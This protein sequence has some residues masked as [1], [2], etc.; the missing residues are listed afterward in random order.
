MSQ[1]KLHSF[2]E[3]DETKKLEEH[4]TKDELKQHYKLAQHFQI[5]KA[6]ENAERKLWAWEVKTRF[7]AKLEAYKE[8]IARI[9]KMNPVNVWTS[10]AQDLWTQST[11]FNKKVHTTAKAKMKELENNSTLVWLGIALWWSFAG[12]MKYASGEKTMWWMVAD[13]FLKWNFSSAVDYFISKQI[14]KTDI[15][16]F[17]DY[18]K[19]L[20]VKAPELPKI[21]SAPKWDEDK[22]WEDSKWEDSKAQDTDNKKNE[23]WDK[24]EKKA[25]KEKKLDAEEKARKLAE[26]KRLAESKEKNRISTRAKLYSVWIGIIKQASLVTFM[27]EKEMFDTNFVFDSM[28]GLSLSSLSKFYWEYSPKWSNSLT[29]EENEKKLSTDLVWLKVKLW[30]KEN[31]VTYKAILLMLKSVVNQNHS[32]IIIKYKLGKKRLEHFF[33]NESDEIRGNFMKEW[34]FTKKEILAIRKN[35]FDYTYLTLEQVSII[36]SLSYPS[37][38][39]ANELA[40]W[41]MAWLFSWVKLEGIEDEIKA[42]RDDLLSPKIVSELMKGWA[43]SW[44]NII[45]GKSSTD[46]IMLMNTDK[47][48]AQK[49]TVK[50]ERQVKRLVTFKE[51][52]TND[53]DKY[54]LWSKIHNLN[55]TKIV[56]LFL[57]LDWQLIETPESIAMIRLW[58]F[59]ILGDKEKSWFALRLLW[60]IIQNWE[61]DPEEK[62]LYHMIFYKIFLN[63]FP[64]YQKLFNISM[65]AAVSPLQ[66]SIWY[67]WTAIVWAWSTYLLY[68]RALKK[69]PLTVRLLI[70]PAIAYYWTSF[71]GDWF[72]KILKENLN[73]ED[74][75]QVHSIF[76][77]TVLNW[78]MIQWKNNWTSQEVVS[79]INEWKLTEKEVQQ[80]LELNPNGTVSYSPI[81]SEAETAEKTKINIDILPDQ[82]SESLTIKLSTLWKDWKKIEKFYQF[83]DYPK[84]VVV[85]DAS[86]RKQN[87][88]LYWEPIWQLWDR[89]RKSE[90][91]KQGS[92]TW[93]SWLFDKVWDLFDWTVTLNV[94]EVNKKVSELWI[95]PRY[96]IPY[97]QID[98]VNPFDDEW[99]WWS[100]RLEEIIK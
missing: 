51:K 87:I 98:T 2:F 92:I 75:D 94:D 15:P 23:K 24:N 28:K 25:A 65:W 47:D 60:H 14:P 38:V 76:T 83:T 6:L 89:T 8:E 69:L 5:E 79:A 82:G 57:Q 45:L 88:Q 95:I 84:S 40:S 74:F 9:E 3:K 55:Y 48:D 54:G 62:Y 42:R 56:P 37:I 44:H 33:Y 90:D 12:A 80:A 91:L 63:Q 10:W 85:N 29:D 27:Q 41:M 67:G 78:L 64:N 50:E 46:I 39:D 58:I 97:S 99:S 7:G 11:E 30:I 20:D 32:S 19:S 71:F 4:F 66:E 18:F 49:L 93:V 100:V 13:V 81:N 52:L 73:N 70:T 26:E 61:K 72:Q 21:P 96:E 43:D 77:V 22:A 59:Q 16:A 17:W 53:L 68:K 31:A 35:G 34:V 1:E 36:I 86:W